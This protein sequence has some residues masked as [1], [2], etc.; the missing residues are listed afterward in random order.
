VAS[1]P[2]VEFRRPSVEFRRLERFVR[3]LELKYLAPHMKPSLAPPSRDE[4]LDVAAFVVLTHGAIENFIE[5]LTIWMAD[6]V[7]KN[8]LNR[9]RVTRS[10]AALLFRAKCKID[11]DTNLKTTFD[12]IRTALDEAKADRTTAVHKNNGIELKHMRQLLAPLG[13]DIPTDPLLAAS[14]DTLVLIRHQWAHQNRFGAQTPRN[15][16]DV[17]KTADDCLALSQ[18]LSSHIGSFRLYKSE[19]VGS[20]LRS[21]MIRKRL[22]TQLLAT[23]PSNTYGDPTVIGIH[24]AMGANHQT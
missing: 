9:H 10:T 17:K 15:A 11:E 8:W 12:V 14:L 3:E 23:T 18:Q 19:S 1:G 16:V 6:R 5:G 21:L 13:V 24:H 22:T 2:S 7:A 20:S 4:Q